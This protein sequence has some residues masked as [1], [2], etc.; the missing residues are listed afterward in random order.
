M[1]TVDSDRFFSMAEVYDRMA[2]TL[3][4]QYGYLQNEALKILAIAETPSPLVVDLGAGSGIFL[5]KAMESNSQA[6][7]HWVDFS[8]DFLKVAKQRLKRFGDRV[9]F[10]ICAIQDDWESAIGEKADAI[11]SMSAIHHLESERKKTLYRRCHEALKPGGWF[12]NADEMA[13]PDRNAYLQNLRFWADFVDRAEGKIPRAEMHYYSQWKV[14]F[15]GWKRRNIDNFGAS[16]TEGDDIHDDFC[17]Q[18]TWLK[19]SGF[20][21]ADLFVKYRL[22]CVIGGK[23]ADKAD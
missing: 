11:F 4:P 6:R 16:K 17:E 14:H 19:D 5:E 13:T 12:V 23:K 8:D 3:T 2:P 1:G 9:T 21:D 15:D 10:T 22:W 7:C 20:V 18:T